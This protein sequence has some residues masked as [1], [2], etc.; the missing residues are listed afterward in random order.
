MT[1]EK[2]RKSGSSTKSVHPEL[3]ADRPWD[4]RPWELGP[5]GRCRLPWAAGLVWASCC[6]PQ[7]G[8]TNATTKEPGQNSGEMGPPLTGPGL[9]LH[10]LLTISTWGWSFPWP[11]STQN[12]GGFFLGGAQA[13][14]EG[15]GARRWGQQPPVR[16]FVGPRLSEAPRKWGNGLRSQTSRNLHFSLSFYSSNKC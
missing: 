4:C 16:E 11:R 8:P 2:C 13:R 5:G 12:L 7:P 10:N 6:R 14:S 15:G 9:G 3:A 1:Y